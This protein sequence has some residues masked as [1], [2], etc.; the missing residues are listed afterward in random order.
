MK[1][2]AMLFIFLLST[3]L[4]MAGLD[5]KVSLEFKDVDIRDIAKI[6]CKSG[7]FGIALEK[8]IRGNLT[9]SIKDVSVSQA[10]DIV[11]QASGFTWTKIGNTV[12]VTDK[13]RLENQMKVIKLKNF[14]AEEMTKILLITIK[15]DIKV[16][17]DSSGN[18]IVV[19]GS[20][21]AIEKTMMVIGH[22]DRLEPAVKLHL[23]VVRNE[24]TIHEFNFL[25]QPGE[26]IEFD[27]IAKFEPVLVGEDKK[28]NF[29]NISGF[30]RVEKI[31]NDGYCSG[32][33]KAEISNA[34]RKNDSESLRKF[35]AH[36][37]METGKAK[38]VF[39]SRGND[40]VKIYL[41]ITP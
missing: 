35:S 26:K 16:A 29:N 31:S 25:G 14:P 19:N 24:Q 4:V 39:T 2:L 5:E 17:A 22:L 8:S 23:K 11:C 21:T 38:E 27:E 12:F 9:I 30:I 10:L 32:R 15:E 3:S 1:K 40:V 41:T 13:K 20:E 6:I 28:H 7:D 18:S 33:I 36:F 37:S 34:D